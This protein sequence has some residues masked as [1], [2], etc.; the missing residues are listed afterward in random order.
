LAVNEPNEPPVAVGL[1]RCSTDMQEHSIEDQEAEV[2]AWAQATGHELLQIFRDE[3]VSGSELDRPG[4]RALLAFMEASERK[5]TLV[6]WK[7]NRLARPADPREG[8]AL[9]LKI[10]R[11]GWKIHFLQ[12]YTSSGNTLVDS[13]L[14]LVEHHEGGEYLRNLASDTLRG[15]VRRILDGEVPGGK[16]SY[17]YAKVIISEDGSERLITRRTKH[18]KQKEERTKWVVGDP[19]EVK[20]V[21]RIFERYASGKV[22]LA[23]LAAELNDDEIPSPSGKK[24]GS[25]TLRCILR[26]PVYVGDILWNRETSSKFCRLVGGKP[27]RQQRAHTSQNPGPR[28][29][30]KTAYRANAPEDWIRLSDHHEPLVDRALAEKAAEVMQARAR[31]NG[32]QRSVKMVYPLT[33]LTICAQCGTPMNGYSNKTGSYRYRR[34][35][36]MSYNR[37]RT[38]HP[39]QVEADQLERAVLTKLRETYLPDVPRDLLRD[40]IIHVLR[41]RLVKDCPTL[42]RAAIKREHHALEGK[43]KTA[44][45]NMGAVSLAVAKT[46]GEQVDVWQK[47][48]VEIEDLLTQEAA[49]EEQEE[50]I[51]KVADDLLD[52]LGE[53][54]EL[55]EDAPYVDTRLLFHRTIERVELEFATKPPRE[56][57]QRARH[58]F[59][60]GSVVTTPLL[61]VML[62]LASTPALGSGGESAGIGCSNHSTPEELAEI[63]RRAAEGRGLTLAPE[64]GAALAAAAR[65]TPRD[66]L[67]LLAAA[68]DE[69]TV[70]GVDAIDGAIA[71]AVLARLGVDAGGL[72]ERDRRYLAALRSARRGAASLG[73]LAARLGLTR[74]VVTEVVEPFLLRRGLIELTSRGRILTTQGLFRAGGAGTAAR[75]AC[76]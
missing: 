41:W 27:T 19:E 24:W 43:I 39:Y 60:R 14:S 45:E 40:K 33:G 59:T 72:T 8:I 2:R 69:A 13:I 16:V 61:S 44:I 64:A 15:Q 30:K 3:G 36:C 48:R 54:E 4:V 32:R 21:R 76:A 66:A 6:L 58:R 35:A 29:S 26:N 11:L 12:G 49:R 1:V 10:D 67:R 68:R 18:R 65:D 74:S 52:M 25:V 62:A 37:N 70:R 56:G 34:Y 57:R 51:E 28:V 22:G 38:C 55:A 7:R 53:L 23:T 17:G 47:R 75:S 73:S 20:T 9:E 71:G 5:G 50:D 46:L 63:L 31:C 42:D